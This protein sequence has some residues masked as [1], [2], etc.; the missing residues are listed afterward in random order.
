MLRS[1]RP[2]S[3]VEAGVWVRRA[4]DLPSGLGRGRVIII[5]EAAHPMRPSSQEENQA[6]AEEG[7]GGGRAG[8]ERGG[9]GVALLCAAHVFMRAQ[10]GGGRL[11]GRAARCALPTS[12]DTG[13]YLQIPYLPPAPPA[14]H[15]MPHLP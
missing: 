13:T 2:S 15:L 14:S 10:W 11:G 8:E 3:V 6:S 5:G 12:T 7:G 1:S 4:K 9:R